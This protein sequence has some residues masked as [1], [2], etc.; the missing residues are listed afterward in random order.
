[1]QRDA[2]IGGSCFHS[3]WEHPHHIF[4]RVFV[5]VSHS[6]AIHYGFLASVQLK[7]ENSCQGLVC[8]I[9]ELDLK[10]DC[11]IL[12][13]S[14]HPELF[15]LSVINLAR[16]KSSFLFKDALH[17]FPDRSR[18]EISLELSEFGGNNLANLISFFSYLF[19]LLSNLLGLFL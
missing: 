4:W 17:G 11:D 15:I 12:R 10:S 13:R 5:V 18:Q 14:K 2:P 7:K 9:V 16:L 1:L 3:V 8:F 19:I 6:W